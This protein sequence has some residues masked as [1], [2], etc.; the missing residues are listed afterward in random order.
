MV[1]FNFIKTMNMPSAKTSFG[2]FGQLTKKKPLR[3]LVLGYRS[4]GKTGKFFLL[5][6]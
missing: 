1:Y 4:V 2:K 6:K 5:Y 3:I